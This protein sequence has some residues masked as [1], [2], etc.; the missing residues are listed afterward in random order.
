MAECTTISAPYLIGCVNT[1]VDTVESTASQ[2][3]APCAMSAAAAISITS[4]VG[5]QGVSIQTSFTLPFLTVLASAPGSAA[6][7]KSRPSPHWSQNRVIQLRR[8]QY[9]TLGAT[10][11]SP[12]FKD[13]TT[14][15]AAAMPELNSSADAPASTPPAVHDRR[16]PRLILVL[17]SNTRPWGASDRPTPLP[18]DMLRRCNSGKR[19]ILRGGC[20]LV[21]SR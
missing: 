12:G 16:I 19:P 8:P 4:Q 2:A 7:N 13:C 1:G 18:S 20:A 9:I 5:L 15:I 10:I 14:A 11:R 6:S 3:S 17:S 21:F